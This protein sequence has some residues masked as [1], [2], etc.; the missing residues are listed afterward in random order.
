[1]RKEVISILGGQI[2]LGICVH[3]V[4]RNE[5]L[6]SSEIVSN[7]VINTKY[8]SPIRLNIRTYIINDHEIEKRL[9]SRS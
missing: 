4:K 7:S 6:K 1:M 9:L 3:I 2:L 5:P 8:T